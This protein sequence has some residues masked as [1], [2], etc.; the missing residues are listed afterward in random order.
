[1]KMPFKTYG[2]LLIARKDKILR[3]NDQYVWVGDCVG[4]FSHMYSEMYKL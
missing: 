4:V 3:E 2:I 1:M